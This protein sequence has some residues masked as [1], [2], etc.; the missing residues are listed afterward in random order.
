MVVLTD[1]GDEMAGVQI[2]VLLG[3]APIDGLGVVV[4]AVVVVVEVV[5]DEV[6]GREIDTCFCAW[7]R[8]GV[9]SV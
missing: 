7:G 4:A 6:A 5:K 8:G 1:R 3:T 9:G 2:V